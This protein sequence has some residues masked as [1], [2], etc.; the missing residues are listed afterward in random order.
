MP[1][2]LTVL[3][4]APMAMRLYGPDPANPATE[5]RR[6]VVINGATGP[7]PGVTRDVD[8]E[9]FRDWMRRNA[10]N[11]AVVNGLIREAGAGDLTGSG[12][13]EY[14]FQPALDRAATLPPSVPD[15]VGQDAPQGPLVTADDMRA[16]SDEDHYTDAVSSNLPLGTQVETD[17]AGN[18]KPSDAPAPD[19]PEASKKSS[20]S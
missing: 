17:A 2:T 18:F 13:I 11:D 3:S 12:E 4:N 8:A 7:A 9:F 16:H 19:A 20:K 1:E 15:Q 6:M 5:T 10:G 14:G